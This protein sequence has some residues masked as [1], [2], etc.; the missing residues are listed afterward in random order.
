MK[1]YKREFIHLEM[2]SWDTDFNTLERTPED[3]I[4]MLLALTY[5]K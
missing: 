1:L 3:N 4:N 2:L 5:L